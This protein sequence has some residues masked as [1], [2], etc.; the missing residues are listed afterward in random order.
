MRRILFILLSLVVTN[1]YAEDEIP[2]EA[3]IP[4]KNIHRID[5]IVDWSSLKI[6]SLT[7][8]EWI[9]IRQKENPKYDARIELDKQLKTQLISCCIPRANALLTKYNLKFVRF[10]DTPISIIIIPLHINKNGK[11]ECEFKFQINETKEVFAQFNLNG[12]MSA[13]GSLQA[14]WETIF[15]NVGNH[16]GQYLKKKLKDIYQ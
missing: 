11:W 1:I 10:Q 15:E 4:L 14:K 9:E 13:M 12:R 5:V 8:E 7:Q 3:F 16:L 2:S 6:D